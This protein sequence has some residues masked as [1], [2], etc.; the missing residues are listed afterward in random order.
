MQTAYSVP[1]KNRQSSQLVQ[2]NG[3]A[4]LLMC[5][6]VLV[7]KSLDNS[8]VNSLNSDLISYIGLAAV[9]FGYSG[10]KLLNV[11]LQCR[12]SGLVLHSLGLR[13]QNT[14]LSRLNIWQTKHLLRFY[15]RQI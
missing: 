8:L 6:V 3:H 11:G 4:A 9:A 7:Q 13:N 10:L 2:L 5:S 12:L 1:E 14:L 15:H